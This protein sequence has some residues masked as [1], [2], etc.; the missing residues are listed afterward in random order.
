M[1]TISPL[2]PLDLVAATRVG[3]MLISQPQLLTAV[4]KFSVPIKVN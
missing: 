1:M 2:K 4:S 3:L